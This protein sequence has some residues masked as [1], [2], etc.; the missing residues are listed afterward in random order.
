MAADPP[1]PAA[2][3]PAAARGAETVGLCA[4]FNVRNAARLI[5]SLY[6]EVLAPS[7]LKTTQFAILVSVHGDRDAT[8]QSLATA[9]G[10][11]PSTMTRTVRPLLDAAWIDVRAGG[12]R[13]VKQ[14]V[15]TTAGKRKLAQCHRLWS[16][17]QDQ[18]RERIGNDRFARLL[19]DLSEV[20]RVLRE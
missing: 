9:L 16:Q 14:V 8:M 6:D 7:G 12:D 1:L 3:E 5:T 17:A 20:G 13:R 4:C 19:A 15:L 2:D 10:I 11:D 18:L